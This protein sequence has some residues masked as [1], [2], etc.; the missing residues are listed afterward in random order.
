MKFKL[1]CILLFFS[2][3]LGCTKS[4][5]KDSLKADS[6]ANKYT[7]LAILSNSLKDKKFAECVEKELIKNTSNL[8]IIPEVKFRDAMFPWFERKT[9]PKNL[10]ELLAILSK[11]LIKNRIKNLGVELLIYVHGHTK[12][13]DEGG[14]PYYY[15]SLYIAKRETNI[16]TTVWDL[17]KMDR[18]GDT[19]I[20]VK[21]IIVAGDICW[22]PYIIHPVFS[23][24]YACNETAKRISNY[25]KGKSQVTDK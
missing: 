17:N 5:I 7:T 23:E 19:D 24:S 1:L 2:I 22:F 4:Q 3:M 13:F 12:T 20:S 11:T 15:G 14:I 16:W 9:A 18:A 8:K 10:E 6:R 21:G 25:L